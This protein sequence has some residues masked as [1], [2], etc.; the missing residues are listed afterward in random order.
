MKIKIL[1]ITSMILMLIAT[2]CNFNYTESGRQI[3][4]EQDGEELSLAKKSLQF[5]EQNKTDSLKELFY[6]AIRNIP[7]IKSLY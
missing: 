4:L 3:N 7:L 2:G 5:I 6:L 1:I